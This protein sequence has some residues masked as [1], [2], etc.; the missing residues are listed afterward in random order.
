MSK[1]TAVF[2]LMLAAL[3]ALT[4]CSPM[5]TETAASAP[6]PVAAKTSAPAPSPSLSATQEP[7]ATPSPTQ[8]PTPEPT[9]SPA[10]SVA[11]GAP[12]AIGLYLTVK[13]GRRERLSE[14]KTVWKRGKDIGVFNA[15][16]TDEAVV[17]G[18]YRRMFVADWRKYPN[19]KEYKIGYRLS[20]T[21]KSGET[22]TLVIRSPKD[23]PKDPDK[24]FY[25][26]IEVY[27]YDGINIQGWYSHLLE[28]QMK[29][30]TLMTYIKLTAGKQMEQVESAK[31]GVFVFHGDEDFD[32]ETGE[33]IG[34]VYN[35]IPV[36]N[37]K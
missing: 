30:N 7:T 6:T 28:S 19:Y 4:A 22:V 12:D 25:Q 23:A 17:K 34:P 14:Y 36:I 24:Y 32:A 1:K 21:L 33:Y 15:F 29:E 37:G 27:L 18:D 13:A 8:S 3:L 20:F 31:L 2:T 10:P 35:E 26:F 9:P 11:E 16:A 5:V